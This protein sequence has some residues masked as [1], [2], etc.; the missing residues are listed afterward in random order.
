MNTK[1]DSQSVLNVVADSAATPTRSSPN[2]DFLTE[3]IGGRLTTDESFISVL[4]EKMMTEAYLAMARA[5]IFSHND[6]F[7][8]VYIADLKPDIVAENTLQEI[9]NVNGIIDV[10][11]T[12]K[13]T[14]GLPD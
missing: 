12:I 7:D 1:A 14:D 4:A 2:Y 9:E 6:P 3:Q 13:F 5:V 8:S 10:S 11:S